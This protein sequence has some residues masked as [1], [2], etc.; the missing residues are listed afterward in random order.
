VDFFTLVPISILMG[1]TEPF[2]TLTPHLPAGSLLSLPVLTS[3]IGSLV[4][5]AGFQVFIFLNIRNW[6]FY[7]RM[8]FFGVSDITGSYESTALVFIANF[9]Y[10]ITCMV[11]SISK[12]FRQ[13]LYTN[14][15]FALSL[16]ILLGF[17]VYIV[18]SDDSFITSLMSLIE[19]GIE[20]N[21][22]FFILLV[23]VANYLASYMFEKLV[24]W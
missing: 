7:K 13:P 18:V 9:Q 4:I 10:I 14:V 8:N 15:W 23:V 11:F 17:D 22:R 1:Y 2:S 16:V 24:V 21:Y 6:P 3:V 12:P 20:L 19:E 5:Q